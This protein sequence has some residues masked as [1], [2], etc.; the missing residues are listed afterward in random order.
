MPCSGTNRALANL[1][2]FCK[3]GPGLSF[4]FGLCVKKCILFFA[5]HI[6][7]YYFCINHQSSVMKK[8]V[9]FHYLPIW[10][11]LSFSFSLHAQE[12]LDSLLSAG[13]SCMDEYNTFGA[14]QYYEQAFSLNDCDATRLALANCVYKRMDY[15]RCVKLLS[16]LHDHSQTH[17]SLRQLV[18]SSQKLADNDALVYWGRMLNARFPMDGEVVARLATAYAQTEQPQNGAKCAE[19]YFRKDTSNIEVNRALADCYFLCQDYPKAADIYDR[20]LSLGDSTFNTLYSSGMCYSQMDSLEL[21]HQR[22]SQAAEMNEYRHYGCVQRL[23]TICNELKRYDEG[24]KHLSRALDLILPD[25]VNM[26]QLT[27]S[28]AEAYYE[29]EHYQ[30]AIDIWKMHLD[31]NPNSMATLFNLGQTYGMMLADQEN[32]KKYYEQFLR[33]AEKEP[34]NQKLRLMKLQA[35]GALQRIERNSLKQEGKVNNLP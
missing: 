7:F 4:Q 21:A 6:V 16:S 15:R 31:Y 19:E 20:L 17:E 25:T 8:T 9:I 30:E 23:G 10:V 26:R 29:S 35:R 22:L 1:F 12:S 3:K 27:L 28:L 34:G 32:E 14:L 18:F 24:V 33:L 11:M 2:F 5:K 13:D